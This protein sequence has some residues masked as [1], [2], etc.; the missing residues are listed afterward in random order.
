MDSYTPSMG[1]LSAPATIRRV[2]I[3]E[4]CTNCGW[5]SGLDEALFVA[6]AKGAC[7]HGTQREDGATDANLSQTS[8]LRV[9]RRGED[10][11]FLTFIAD[12]CPAQVIRL[13]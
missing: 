10:A 9:P 8:D 13:A 7:I 1:L 11:T 3:A 12:G 2:W 6:S 4:G 5:C